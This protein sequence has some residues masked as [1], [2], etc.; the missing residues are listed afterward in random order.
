MEGYIKFN[1]KIAGSQTPDEVD[2]EGIN[3]LRSRLHSLGLIG[4]TPEG[5]G[6][7]NISRRFGNYF[8]ISC[9]ATGQLPVLS[10]KDF[11]IIQAYSFQNNEVEISGFKPASSESLTHIAVYT[12]L[13]DVNI[14]A[15]IHN[16]RIWKHLIAEG[17]STS[18]NADYGTV[19]IAMEV[20]EYLQISTSPNQS[21]ALAGHQDGV[22]IIG[23]NSENIL[24]EL[25]RFND[26]INK[27]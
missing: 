9:S 13:E 23:R 15:H 12:S 5:I 27:I 17:K 8:I 7:G 21:F 18:G 2:I 19:E 3:D 4:A 14:V 26:L 22:M 1:C 11:A 10:E 16:S 20:R 25:S 6:Y 24:Q